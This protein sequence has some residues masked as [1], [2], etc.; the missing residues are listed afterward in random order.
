MAVAGPFPR[1]AQCD[2]RSL[3]F[4]ALAHGGGDKIKRIADEFS[5]A[6]VPR[7]ILL[8][9][10]H[11]LCELLVSH[12]RFRD[13]ECTQHGDGVARAL[14]PMVNVHVYVFLPVG[15]LLHDA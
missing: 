4:P 12:S 8:H 6:C 3:G 1:A 2:G 14:N 11:S 9:Q 15:W 13:F 5:M 10:S 7:L